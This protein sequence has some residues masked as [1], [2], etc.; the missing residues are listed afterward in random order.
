MHSRASRVGLILSSA[1]T[2]YSLPSKL[3]LLDFCLQITGI[4]IMRQTGFVDLCMAT[5]ARNLPL[6]LLFPVLICLTALFVLLVS[7][8]PQLHT[9]PVSARISSSQTA[10]PLWLIQ[11]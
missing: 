3:W 5:S 1:L 10:P 7:S 9:P 11:G 6:R 8:V 4:P 2:W